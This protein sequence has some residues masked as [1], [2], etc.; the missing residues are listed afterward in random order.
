MFATIILIL[1]LQA[2]LC[3]VAF[4]AGIQQGACSTYKKLWRDLN[5]PEENKP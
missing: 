5:A 1:V 2:A 3:G 4:Y